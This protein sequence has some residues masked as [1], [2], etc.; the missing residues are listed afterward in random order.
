MICNCIR[1]TTKSSFIDQTSKTV[2]HHGSSLSP[3]PPP[4]QSIGP[5]WRGFSAYLVNLQY[6]V[7][8]FIHQASLFDVVQESNQ[9]MSVA[10]TWPPAT[11]TVKTVD[12]IDEC[13]LMEIYPERG[14]GKALLPVRCSALSIWFLLWVAVVGPK[15]TISLMD[16]GADAC[17]LFN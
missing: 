2:I 4:F 7:P 8:S 17:H 12:L 14:A 6:S 5:V 13:E 3:P 1:I 15:S 16:S 11:L 9:I 10:S